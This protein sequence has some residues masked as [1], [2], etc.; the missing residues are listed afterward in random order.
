MLEQDNNNVPLCVDLDGTLLRTD[1]LYESIIYLLKK[2]FFYIFIIPFWFLKGRYY[3]KYKLLQYVSPNVS[4]LPYNS[5][6][7]DF[8]KREKEKGRTITLVTASAQALAEKVANYLEIFDFVYASKDG[9]NLVHQNKADFL[10]DRFGYKNFDYIGDSYKDIVVWENSNTAHIVTN[11]NNLINI[12]E[13]KT[14]IGK[15]FNIPKEGLSVYLKQIRV[16]QWIKN[17]LIFVPTFLAHKTDFNNFLDLILAFFSFSFIASAIYVINDLADIESDRNHSTKKYRP[18]AS[19]QMKILTSFKII[20]ILFILGFVLSLFTYNFSFVIILL[21]YTVITI[22]YS[23]YLKKLYLIDIIILSILFTI[24]L[25]AGGIITNT[26][27]SPWLLSFTLFIF[28]SLGALKRYTE[29]KGL[30]SSQKVK[31]KGRDYYIDEIPLLLNLG[32]STGIVSIL[33]FMLYINNPDVSYLYNNPYYLYL[34]IPIL[35]YWILRMWFEAHR[36]LMN[37]DPIS[38]AIKD[39]V[40]IIIFIL[41]IVI[42][43]IATI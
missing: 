33:V 1:L 32:I 40:S 36:G 10:I 25:F 20:P 6:I 30:L 7:I 41:I 17:L 5:E 13:Q 24:R 16:H 12:V 39:K 18:L 26:T 22:L 23:F 9:I 29:L 2:N 42:A 28:L 35:L 14:K 21:I 34:I 43:L 11:D 15:I 31:T 4:S 3:T 19:G 38:Y 27:I 37:D 8:I